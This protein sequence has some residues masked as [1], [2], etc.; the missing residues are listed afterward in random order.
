MT[1]ENIPTIAE[2]QEAK[3]NMDSITEFIQST[4]DTLVD[5]YGGTRKTLRGVESEVD[6]LISDKTDE[7]DQ[8][9]TDAQ[10]SAIEGLQVLG[11]TPLNGGVWAAG[12]TFNS[13]L[14]FMIYNDIKYKLLPST[15]LPYGPTDT[16][17]D[18]VFVQPYGELSEASISQGEKQSTSLSVYPSSFSETASIT[19]P[20]NECPVG[21][22]A[23]RDAVNNKIYRT[24]KE[25]SGVITALDFTT[26][27]AT[28]GGVTVTISRQF[29]VENDILNVR[30]F[31]AVGDGITNDGPAIQSA[32]DY[33]ASIQGAKVKIP[34]GNYLTLQT[35][36]LTK[37]TVLEGD[38]VGTPTSPD[39]VSTIR[40]G[41]NLTYLVTQVDESD[42]DQPFTISNLSIHGNKD[43]GFTV[44]TGLALRGRSIR[45]LNCIISDCTGTGLHLLSTNFDSFDPSW[46]N[47]VRG[48]LVSR[49]DEYGIKNESSDSFFSE[50]YF[51]DNAKNWQ[52]ISG[53]NIWQGNH[54]DNAEV[55][56][57]VVWDDLWYD[58]NPVAY[59]MADRFVGN[60]FDNNIIGLQIDGTTTGSSPS[61]AESQMIYNANRFRANNLHVDFIGLTGCSFLNAVFTENVDK[62]SDINPSDPLNGLVGGLRWTNCADG[63]LVGCY[64]DRTYTYEGSLVA[65]P[66]YYLTEYVPM[67]ID[68][69]SNCILRS[70]RKGDN[71]GTS[72][73][74][75]ERH[76]IAQ[77]LSGQTSVTVEH[78]LLGQPACV[79][80]GQRG[81]GA[82]QFYAQRVTNI[83]ETTF[84]I[85]VD[86]AVATDQVFHWQASFTQ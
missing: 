18:L 41:A 82:G 84:D 76:T 3:L 86:S 42:P 20:Y 44:G 75:S 1:T 58:F 69:P 45:V 23:L 74:Y 8:V 15:S 16:T 57:Q 17:P 5:Q 60:Y 61:R 39:G 63:M 28:I 9:I 12:Q 22:N 77:I 73:L 29:K 35:L 47:W 65:A 40:A 38:G 50:N 85:E 81:G 64:F 32:L 83:T 51:S 71:G 80:T 37:G 26:G 70:T 68:R 62:A 4:M 56:L 54:F 72:G 67:F 19:A 55:G 25:V 59:R 24:S 6:N 7:L 79:T 46:V 14:E 27:V 36:R 33:A 52:K 10:N 11:E 31:G 49:N 30:E 21:T 78:R 13:Y 2:V 66:P 53:G 43:N 48:C 34:K